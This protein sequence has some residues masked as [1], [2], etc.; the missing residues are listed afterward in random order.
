MPDVHEILIEIPDEESVTP[1]APASVKARNMPLSKAASVAKEYL[2]QLSVSGED[3]DAC[4]EQLH[5]LIDRLCAQDT[6]S[7][8]ADD[9]HNFVVALARKDEYELACRVLERGLQVFP[10]NVDLLADYLQYGVSCGKSEE[11][12]KYAKVLQKIPKMRWTWRGFAF[13]V[14]YILHLAGESDSEKDILAKRT[15]MLELTGDFRKYYP[16]SEE[17]YRVE[18]EV[19]S[20]LNEPENELAPLREAMNKLRV[21]PKCALRYADVQFERGDYPEAM[22]AIERAIRDANQTQSSVSEGYLYYLSAL[23]RIA[24]LESEN[25]AREQVYGIYSDFNIALREISSSSSYMDVIR[26]KTNALVTKTG[27]EIPVE[28]AQLYDIYT[29]Q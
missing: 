15:Q 12:K 20:E 1:I 26:S 13:L 25:A 23:C 18:A 11:C 4:R 10:K 29:Q 9:F 17:A 6:I 16:Y 28:Y 19:F 24:M 27:V 3:D 7:G 21:C 2:R 8:D 22:T 14:R 5:E